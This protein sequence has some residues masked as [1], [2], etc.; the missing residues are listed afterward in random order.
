MCKQQINRKAIRKL[1]TLR[2]RLQ[3][4]VIAGDAV[5]SRYEAVK[6]LGADILTAIVGLIIGIGAG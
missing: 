5:K 6:G 1:Y 2:D 3:A 4:R